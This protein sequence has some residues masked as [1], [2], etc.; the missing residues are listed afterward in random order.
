MCGAG[1]YQFCRWSRHP[2]Y[3]SFTPEYYPSTS[4]GHDNQ[5]DVA[6]ESS[7][8]S[9]FDGEHWTKSWK[10]P[11][12]EEQLRENLESN[13]F[14]S[15][16]L[17]QVPLSVS[18]IVKAVKDSPEQLLEEAIGFSIVG[19][20][21]SL[22]YD[23]LQKARKAKLV[24]SNL[25]PFHLATS[26]LDGSKTCCIIFKI[27]FEYV[28]DEWRPKWGK[29]NTNDLGHTLLD[30]LMITVLRNHTSVSPGTVDNAQKM[31]LLFP[32]QEVDIC[33]RWDADSQCYQEL[34]LSGKPTIPSKWRHNF[35]HT[36]AQAVYHCIAE[37]HFH[38]IDLEVPSGLFLNYCSHCGGKLQ[39]SSLQTL[40]MTSF[41]LATAGCQNE[42]LFGMIC[43]LLSLLACEVDPRKTSEISLPILLVAKE[44]DTCSHEH[45]TPAELAEC[46]ADEAGELWPELTKTGWQVLCHILRVAE[47]S[48]DGI[49]SEIDSESD[50]E[51]KSEDNNTNPGFSLSCWHHNRYRV[52]KTRVFGKDRTLGHLWAAAQTE[53]L[54]YR[55]Q[56]EEDPWTSGKFDLPGVLKCLRE[57]TIPSIPLVRG[58]M[59]KPYCACGFFEECSSFHPPTRKDACS[60]HISN[61]NQYSRETWIDQEVLFR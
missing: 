17:S 7:S 13:D 15:I 20:N 22:L 39:L 30:N 29:D 4:W 10:D 23:L 49:Q 33:G 18:T 53:L 40:I 52:R 31:R 51:D 2:D 32:G 16:N 48:W 21:A 26:Y 47:E 27:L 12:F 56:R 43:C 55:R 50:L 11:P 6:S 3:Y 54:T 41:Y 1:P 19:R 46:L 14:S 44:G 61:M 37:M 8:E 24:P 57:R 58:S 5:S 25:N 42:D 35:C 9:E 59:M 45:Y 28:L 38:S 36:S 60:S 34:L